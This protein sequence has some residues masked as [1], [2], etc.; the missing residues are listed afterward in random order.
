M[1]GRQVRKGSQHGEIYDHFAVE[2]TYDDGAKM[3]S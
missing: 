1:G 2:Y 3:M